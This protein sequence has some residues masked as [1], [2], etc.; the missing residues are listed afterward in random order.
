MEPCLIAVKSSDQNFVIREM[1]S[2]KYVQYCI[3]CLWS[4][5]FSWCTIL[6]LYGR[7]FRFLI[8]RRHVPYETSVCRDNLSSD[9]LVCSFQTTFNT[10]FDPCRHVRTTTSR[11]VRCATSFPKFRT[12][13]FV[14]CFVWNFFLCSLSTF[15]YDEVLKQC[16]TMKQRFYNVS[17]MLEKNPFSLRA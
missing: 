7:N 2:R 6:T 3:L 12:V 15:A 1:C 17:E 14:R 11:L 9:F 10:F 5:Y 4:V 16:S 13:I 8:K